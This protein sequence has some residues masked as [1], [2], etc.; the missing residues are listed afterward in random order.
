MNCL[1]CGRETTAEQVFCENCLL[2]MEKYPVK[3]GTAVKLPSPREATTFRRTVKR[4]TISPEEQVR[5]LKKRVLHLTVA[6]LACIALV[7]LLARPALSHLLED[8][9]KKGQ[10][11]NVITP[12]TAAPETT[13]AAAP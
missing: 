5:S 1:K 10:N 3:P 12:T 13:A 8:H 2:E 11:Y 7:L 6:L 4:R 9:Y